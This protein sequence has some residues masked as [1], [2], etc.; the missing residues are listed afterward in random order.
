MKNSMLMFG[1]F[2]L[3]S[4]CYITGYKGITGA[5]AKKKI[6]SAVLPLAVNIEKPDS[7]IL[8]LTVVV[9]GLKD[10]E[11]YYESDV[12]NCIESATTTTLVGLSS[13]QPF[14]INCKIGH[15]GILN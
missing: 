9:S 4:N 3:M 11:Y 7:F 6:L 1:V 12:E 14:A 13:K 8:S 2:V 15:L 10:N 5:E